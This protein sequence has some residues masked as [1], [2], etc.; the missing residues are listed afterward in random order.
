MTRARRDALLFAGALALRALHVA[1]VHRGPVFRYLFIDSQFYDGVGRRLAAGDGFPEGPFF[2]NVLYGVVLGGVYAVFGSAEGGRLAAL[3]LQSVLGAAACVLTVRLGE[4]LA[5]PRE[6]LAAGV[7][8]A[9]LGPAIFYDGALLTPSV[10]LFLTVAATL[11]AVR[12][13]A[14]GAGARAALL[15]GALTGLLV[16]GRA[17]HALLLAGW[18]PLV[19]R[20][21]GGA[22]RALLTAAACAA[23]VL[24]VTLRNLAV[25]GE[26]IPV[27]ANGGMAL[28][29]G[30]H[31][32]AT[33]IYSEPPFL[34]NP[35]PEREAEDYRAEA[36]RRARRELTLAG[37]SAFWTRATLERWAADP[38]A[39]ARLAARK[40]RF[41]FHAVESQTNLSYY[42]AR[43]FS[44]VL[45]IARLHLGWILPFAILGFA[46]RRRAFI[47]PAIPVAAS[48]LTCALF[49]T[50]SEYRHPV[51]PC[52]LL[53][54]AAGAR[55]AWDLLR[56]GA[57]ATRVAVAAGLLALLVA[58]NAR[59]PFLSRLTSRRVDYYNFAALAEAEGRL[60]DAERF[61]RRSI[62]IDPSWP[63]SRAKLAEI[64]QRSGRVREAGEEHGRAESLR[65]AP[66]DA[67]EAPMTLFRAG[68]FAE[69]QSAF[70]ALAA[71]GGG[72][73]SIAL[74]NAG[75]CAM[76][77]ERVAEA[78]S[79]LT[80]AREADPGYASP[81]IH[82]GRLALAQGRSDAAAAYAREAL[83]IAP[84]DGRAQ[85]L[86][87][88]ATGQPAPDGPADEEE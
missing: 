75:L 27:S 32:Q 10:L 48:L 11:A 63:V 2:M 42:F 45:Q 83:S 77:R 51:V 56:G 21:A 30:N 84:S 4:A 65:G 3:C 60:E 57:P 85:R 44:P 50:S 55:R 9:I 15:L 24:P 23:V 5:R 7:L 29:A 41:W 86:L 28:W 35:V 40:L 13:A 52:L 38:A 34:S 88:R 59:D 69:A 20:G 70:L 17:S 6:G 67:L 14:P 43:D 53:F 8:L 81:V 54:A 64:L 19:A 18:T 33:G 31:E 46:W 73:R 26:W 78:E 39:A 47:V 1:A 61:A 25:S 37:S 66:A 22:K 36:S 82:L 49:Y 71:A 72:T 76:R 74:N 12:A 58:T 87:A 79:L 16:L 62:A 80:A 68:R